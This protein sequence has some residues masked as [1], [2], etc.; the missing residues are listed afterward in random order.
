MFRQAS[1]AI[2][3]LV[4]ILIS[5]FPSY[6]VTDDINEVPRIETSCSFPVFS[7]SFI[8]SLQTSHISKDNVEV[9]IKFSI[10]HPS[11][12]DVDNQIEYNVTLKPMADLYPTMSVI[13][14]DQLAFTNGTVVS[15][16]ILI[17]RG[18]TFLL[19][20]TWELEVIV[21]T[22][23]DGV[24]GSGFDRVYV[25]FQNRTKG[26]PVAILTRPAEYW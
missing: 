3:G 5:I 21:G 9:K 25:S 1:W 13:D 4:G 14:N 15:S 18:E 12:H 20:R 22:V 23:N 26:A 6:Q 19:Q 10:T 17:P 8:K 11:I 16:R 24:G 7:L 2:S